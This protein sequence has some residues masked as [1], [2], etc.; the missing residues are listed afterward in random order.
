MNIKNINFNKLYIEQKRKS[1][2]KAKSNNSWD[3]KALYMQKKVKNSIY[4]KQF[5]KHINTKNCNTIL[6][7]GCGTGNISLNIKKKF[8]K[9]YALDYSSQMLKIY[10]QNAKNKNISNINT[11]LKSWDEEF[12]DVPKCDIVIAS[13][14]MQGLDDIEK[15]LLK[16]DSFTKK[17]AYV[18]Y[19]T[20][21]SFF[22]KKLYKVLDIKKEPSPDYIYILNILYNLDINANLNFI[23]AEN[24]KNTQSFEK[25]KESIEWELGKL[26]KTQEK[27]LK[28]YYEKEIKDIKAQNVKWALISWEK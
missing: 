3:K 17:R 23:E 25:Y 20:N 28:K 12:K 10:L 5:I 22:D 15:Y 21:K 24:N 18:T 6:D 16:I 19:K 26:N 14:A 13:R 7:I 11:Y 8:K 9:I 2:Y 4:N 1:F 27:N